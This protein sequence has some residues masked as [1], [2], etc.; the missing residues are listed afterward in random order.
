MSTVI[1][2]MTPYENR[3]ALVQG[4]LTQN[5]KLDD[6]SSYALAVSVLQ[7]LDRIPE[8]MR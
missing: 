4:V 6:K 1:N 7:A 8:K 3:I 5:T 2:F